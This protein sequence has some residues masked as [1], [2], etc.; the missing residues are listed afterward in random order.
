MNFKNMVNENLIP[1]T[2][3]VYKLKQ[4]IP[5]YEEFMKN[6]KVD[7]VIENSYWLENQNQ[8]RGYGPATYGIVTYQYPLHLRIECHNWLGDGESVEVNDAYEAQRQ[9]E[10]L[11]NHSWNSSWAISS[12]IL[13]KCKELVLEALVKSEQRPVNGY[14]KVKGNFFGMEYK[15]EY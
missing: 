5:T 6:Y 13:D 7:K 2:E 1:Q 8:E 3:T 9:A 14:I 4:E 15:C 11:R 10:R 12:S